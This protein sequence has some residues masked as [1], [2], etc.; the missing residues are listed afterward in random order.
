M[1]TQ[2]PEVEPI[3]PDDLLP[4]FQ[5]GEEQAFSPEEVIYLGVRYLA[6][7]CDGARGAD[8]IG[9]NRMHTGMGRALAELPFR[10]WSD[11]QLWA[12]RRMLAVYKHTQIE[13]F[14]DKIPEVPYPVDRRV[15]DIATRKP[16][17]V[18]DPNRSMSLV[19][20]GGD[21]FVALRH[22]YDHL[23][24]ESIKLMPRQIR[25]WD[26]KMGCW[27]LPLEYEVLEAVAG[28]ATEWGYE[29]EPEVMT[30][31]DQILVE[32]GE[33]I[34]LSHASEGSI[35]IE[36]FGS[37]HLK[38]RPFQQAGVQYAL[39]VSNMETGEGVLI[40]DQP[41][42]GKSCQALGVAQAL[43]AFPALIICPAS[44]KWNWKRE[45]SMW[46]PD[47][48]VQVI[49]GGKTYPLV[50]RHIFGEER[51]ADVFIIGYSAI[52]FEK[53]API[54]AELA[55]AAVI[56]DEVHNLKSVSARQTRII[57]K[58]LRDLRGKTIPI[59]LSGTPMVNSPRDF[60]QM[61]RL[62]GHIDNFGGREKFEADFSSTSGATLRKLNAKARQVFM[63][64]RL[65]KDV[66][67]ELPPKVYQTVD[68]DL[69]DRAAYNVAEA[70]VA[71]YFASKKVESDRFRW[72]CMDEWGSGLARI[73]TYSSFEEYYEV[74]KVEHYGKAYAIAAQAE[75]LIRWEALK[76]AALAGKKRACF[77]WIDEFLA[78]TDEKV[79]LFVMHTDFGREVA[80]RYGAEFIHGGVSPDKRLPIVD[81]FQTDPSRR[82]IVGNVIA[83][84][85]GLTLTAAS[86]VCFL[87]LGWNPKTMEQASDR[88]HRIGQHDSVNIY[89]L[90]AINTIETEIAAII[91]AKRLMAD[92]L[93]DGDPAATQ[94]SIM[95]ELAARLRAKIGG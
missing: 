64:R 68:L 87:E 59:G 51:I 55:P 6:G 62:L 14:W 17:P 33:R 18:K 84:G 69:D 72:Q 9:F 53:W 15:L 32:V 48:R 5:L 91:E 8:G 70:D 4:Y 65:K 31:V 20:L 2:T 77:Q 26:Q 93:Q 56:I 36:G 88:A 73:G 71:H 57:T 35:E 94:K 89:Y 10:Y 78:N 12:A 61:V 23:L 44:V 75:Q 40:A 45:L 37:E 76:Q 46:L 54:L 22:D 47:K 85:E 13:W 34:N 24:V 58:F 27:L 83:M 38:L 21:S 30:R 60:A 7:K 63:V 11:K 3:D 86:N 25:R 82:V 41:G 79:I 74:A 92:A 39:R 67:K 80:E 19:T 50:H 28:F 52:V 90:T 43:D 29:L 16:V 66:M 95:D 49:Q 1:E 42:L 81:R